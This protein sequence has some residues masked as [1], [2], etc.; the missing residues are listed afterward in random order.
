MK[1]IWEKFVNSG[2]VSPRKRVSGNPCKLGVGELQL[3]EAIK[4]Q[5]PSISYKLVK[6]NLEQHENIL[7]GTS[8]LA[9]GR[10]V[11]SCMTRVFGRGKGCLELSKT[12]SV[13]QT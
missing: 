6:N 7:G 9:V 3:V 4:T 8:I 11:Q 5:K 10:A 1:D 13:L 2:S 12:N